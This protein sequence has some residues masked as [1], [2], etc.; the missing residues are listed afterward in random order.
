[1]LGNLLVALALFSGELDV[2][3]TAVVEARAGEQPDPRDYTKQA[4]F[5]AAVVTPIATLVYGEPGLSL[6]LSYSPRVYWSDPN[7]LTSMAPLLLH[8]VDL[9][10]A[11]QVTKRFAL[12]GELIGSIGQP[13]YTTLALTLQ[14]G[15]VP[16]ITEIA[17]AIGGIT[18]RTALT[19]RWELDLDGRLFYWKALDVQPPDPT[20][21]V[22][23]TPA[24]TEQ[25]SAAEQATALFQL[26][27]RNALGFGVAASQASYSSG[28]A[29]YTV[30]PTAT[31]KVHLTPV[32]DLKLILGLQYVR[33]TEPTMPGVTP[34][35]A[36]SG[37][38][39]SPI[40]G[41]EL[42]SRVAR[43]DEVLILANA[44]AGVTYYVDPVIQ[45]AAP[46]AEA[47]AGM[48]GIMLPY[49][50]ATVHA[51]FA[52]TLRSTQFEI[53]GLVP[54]ETVVSLT[55]AVQRL[56]STGFFFEIGGTWAERAPAFVA[57]DFHFDQ[58]Q[59]WVFARLSWFSHPLP[60]Q[61]H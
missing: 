32:D 5:V 45:T 23:T 42:V 34:L 6:R 55:L 1:M 27:R 21:V 58:R 38:A 19:R 10:I 15:T 37:Q 50:L 52:T 16:Q 47:T 61:T 39:V 48:T 22:P 3:A 14:S 28:I 18:T 12:H 29:V 51:D 59:L 44:A 53:N 8:T 9:V 40:G 43:R 57:K 17:S 31:W 54:D 33:A 25:K 26:T 7:V 41:F 24:I 46:R 13:D 2:Q 11:E 60:R 36:P 56:I 35:L 49:W 30:G 4:A 20:A